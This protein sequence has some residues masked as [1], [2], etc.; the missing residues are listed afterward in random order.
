[1]GGTHILDEL[2]CRIYGQAAGGYG[3]HDVQVYQFAD[4]VC[5]VD[6]EY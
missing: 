6:A 5:L 1:M 3:A 4:V 2:D